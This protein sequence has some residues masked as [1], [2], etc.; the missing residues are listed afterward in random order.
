ME[1]IC[2]VYSITNII[3]NKK[4]IGQSVDIYVRWRNH[5]SALRNNR[6]NNSH[7]QNAWNVY[8]EENFVF[9]ILSVCSVD[10]IDDVEEEYIKLFDT[11]NRKHGYNMESGGHENKVLS[12]E[13]KMIISIKHKGRKLTDEHKIK[14][15]SSTKGRICSDETRNKISEAITGIKRSDETCNRISNSRKGDKSWSRKPIYCI[16]LNEEFDSIESAHEKY[17]FNSASLCSHLKGRYKSSGKHP[18]T[19]ELLHWV[20]ADNINMNT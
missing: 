15:S 11:M 16:E 20:Y 17:G 1:K 4:Y 12:D 9:E 6:H 18:I 2:G 3:D 5:K 14:I 10:I 19:G 7:L 13:S 8:G